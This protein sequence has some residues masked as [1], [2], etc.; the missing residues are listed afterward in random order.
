MLTY[1]SFFNRII[2]LQLVLLISLPIHALPEQ[3]LVPGGI[4]LLKIPDYTQDTR[5]L[6]EDKRI[7]VFPYQ[8]TWIAMAGIDLSTRPGDYEFSIKRADSPSVKTQITVEHKKYDEQ[9]LT[10]KNKRKVNPN[11][12]D[13]ERIAAES[14]RKIKARKLYSE[15]EANVD[16][17]W[18]ITGR[19]SSI[20]GLRRFFN[21]QER[22]PHSGLDIAALEGTPIKAAAN[23][24][25]IDAGDFFFSGNMI[26]IDHGQGII[27]LYAHLSKIAV[28]PGDA[29]KQGDII[30]NV[31]QTGRV[32]GPHLH[33]AIY[34]N[35]TLID[36]VF[37]LPKDGNPATLSSAEKTSSSEKKSGL[38]QHKTNK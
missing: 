23:G 20:Y 8:N 34:A 25:V 24:T 32:T 18:P 37:M 2:L 28:K 15:T 22:R 19:I 31:G 10:I 6:F 21:E 38:I 17:I 7:A 11:K 14:S 35:Q 36:P 3:A 30:G 27:S 12:K 33:F 29:I 5:V 13:S 4:A 1:R 26:Y 9:H 16:F